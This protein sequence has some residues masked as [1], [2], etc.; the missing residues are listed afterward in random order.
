MIIRNV[1][2]KFKSKDQTIRALDNVSINLENKGLVF[3]VGKSGSGKSTLLNLIGGL[4][5]VTD[6]DIIINN[7]SIKSMNAR[8]LEDYRAMYLGFVFQDFCLIENLTIYENIKLSLSIINKENKGIIENI[9]NDLDISDQ[10]N[11]YPSQLSAGQKQRVAIAR[12]LVK[13]SPIILCDEPTGNL[14][15]KTARQILEILKE[16]SKNR[17]VL[18]VS[19]NMD[20]AYQYGDRIIELLDGCIISDIHKN[21]QIKLSDNVLVIN[22]FNHLT[23]EEIDD[24]NLKLKNGTLDKIVSQKYNF[25]NFENNLKEEEITTSP[26]KKMSFKNA[27]SLATKLFKQSVSSAILCSLISALAVGILFM[28]QS[29]VSFDEKSAITQSF[30]S[31][32]ESSAVVKK[33]YFADS[34]KKNVKSNLLVEFNEDDQEIINNS[35]YKGDVY[36]LYNYSLPVS[37]TYWQLQK[38]HAIDDA[39]N[40]SELY[41]K[42]CYG[43]LVCDE[44]YIEKVFFDSKDIEYIA[45]E[46]EIKDYGIYITDYVADSIKYYRKNEFPSYQSIL[47]TYYQGGGNKVAYI[48]GIIKTNYIDKYQS[49]IDS[50]KEVNGDFSKLAFSQEHN[51]AIEDIISKLGVCYSFNPNFINAVNNYEVRNFVRLEETYVSLI[52]PFPE[53]VYLADAWAKIDKD[54]GLDLP[55]KT[56]SVSLQEINRLLGENY[57]LEEA[58]NLINSLDPYSFRLNKFPA[59]NPENKTRISVRINIAVHNNSVSFIVSEDLFTLLREKEFIAYAVSLNDI[60]TCSLAVTALID[61]PFV[62]LQ[63]AASAALEVAKVVYVFDSIFLLIAFVIILI[64]FGVLLFAS[65][66]IV[67]RNKFNIG[68]MKSLGSKTEDI[69]KVF[70]PQTLLV[71]LLTIFF[72]AICSI[73]LVVAGNSVLVNSFMMYNPN[74]TFESLTILTFLPNYFILNIIGIIAICCVSIIIPLVY[75]HYL[76]PIG[77]IRK[78]I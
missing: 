59:Y 55:E 46:D 12:A 67:K 39:E 56:L 70:L 75:L 48:N 58:K 62:P 41:L 77:I 64:A 25:K 20:D 69:L 53:N 34:L 24:I 27:F 63:I 49:L 23:N 73:V 66:D 42:E 7:K 76:R 47:G 28:C 78:E 13:D 19:H 50:V 30:T 11:K 61:V 52:K 31:L 10:A 74:F 17:L 43:V 6:G 5:T 14:D 54:L 29:F 51:L 45:I 71:C 72:F 32:N 21:E 9:L 15:S 33:A 35:G 60:D 68:V 1:V 65:F 38:E 8:E 16:I 37:L 18:V 26:R 57:S 4:D 40:L 3:V 2:K 44:N 22:D 36:K